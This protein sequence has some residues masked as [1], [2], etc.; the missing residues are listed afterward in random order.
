MPWLAQTGTQEAEETH[1]HV[2]KVTLRRQDSELRHIW[3]PL[4][5]NDLRPS[6]DDEFILLPWMPYEVFLDFAGHS[7]SYRVQHGL[8]VRL[9]VVNG[10]FTPLLESKRSDKEGQSN[11]EKDYREVEDFLGTMVDTVRDVDPFESCSTVIASITL[12]LYKPRENIF[13]T[14]SQSTSTNSSHK[15]TLQYIVQW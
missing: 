13:G 3:C 15:I 11:S 14:S 12:H 5:K 10:S 4:I 7:R 8:E 9:H 2:E 1:L 6:S